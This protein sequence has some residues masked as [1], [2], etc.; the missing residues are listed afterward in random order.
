[1]NIAGRIYVSLVLASF[2]S[3]MMTSIKLLVMPFCFDKIKNGHE[4]HSSPGPPMFGVKLIFGHPYIAVNS[5][6]N[7]LKMECFETMIENLVCNLGLVG[8]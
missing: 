8:K 3:I 7:L 4:P 1:M 5:R 6:S 2:F